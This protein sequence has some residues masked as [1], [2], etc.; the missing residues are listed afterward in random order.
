MAML[1]LSNDSRENGIAKAHNIYVIN[2]KKSHFKYIEMEKEFSKYPNLNLNR[3]EAITYSPGWVGCTMSHLELVKM[4]QRKNLPYII[5]MEDDCSITDYVRFIKILDFLTSKEELSNWDL[6]NGNPT[7]MF[8]RKQ[9]IVPHSSIPK[10]LR[11]M[12]GL[13]T[14]LIIYNRSS[15][16]SVLEIETIY[17]NMPNTAIPHNYAIDKLLS[18]LELRKLCPIPFVST[19]IPTFSDLNNEFSSY[20]RIFNITEQWLLNKV[21]EMNCFVHYENKNENFECKATMAN[22][23]SKKNQVFLTYDLNHDALNILKQ[24]ENVSSIILPTHSISSMEI[25]LKIKKGNAS[26]SLALSIESTKT[27]L[28]NKRNYLCIVTSNKTIERA[29]W[30]VNV[31]LKYLNKEWKVVFVK[32]SS[33]RVL[34]FSKKINKMNGEYDWDVELLDIDCD[35]S[36]FGLSNKI[37]SLFFNLKDRKDLQYLV[38]ID[39]DSVINT[40]H[41]N[42]LLFYLNSIGT[43][44]KCTSMNIFDY[45]YM[46]GKIVGLGNPL[47]FKHQIKNPNLSLRK[48]A[49]ERSTRYDEQLSNEL[50]EKNIEYFGEWYSGGLYI[51]S[52]SLISKLVQSDGF[53]DKSKTQLY[54]DKF[55]GDSI[56]KIYNDELHWKIPQEKSYLHNR[57]SFI[58]IENVKE[59]D[60]HKYSLISENHNEEQFKA[61]FSLINKNT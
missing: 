7:F 17:K 40:N 59:S 35:D 20:E 44:G 61:T 56:R 13:T 16:K 19:Q 38:K 23:L 28:K 49:E 12:Y 41:F 3:F 43:I 58:Q 18:Q 29:E 14:N 9:E 47:T 55:I 21:K 53:I 5:V 50:I 57:I 34:D 15:Y 36:Y 8:E 11:Y 54:E 32:G 45:H 24:Q 26:K 22:Y 25:P 42:K 27:N 31:W 10:L 2:L 1:S 33:D 4:A 51:L 52:H 60:Y 48:C 6:F 46:G 39:D 37:A 30:I